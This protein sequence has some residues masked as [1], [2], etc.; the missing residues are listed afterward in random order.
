MKDFINNVLKITADEFEAIMDLA[1]DKKASL[2]AL[3]KK[4]DEDGDIDSLI[5]S[6]KNELSE[7]CLAM[8]A[9]FNNFKRR[10]K[11]LCSIGRHW[12]WFLVSN[13]DYCQ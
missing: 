11:G 8:N 3:L 1:D 12:F 5:A 10:F 13:W 7:F 4:Y 9:F 6:L 2:K